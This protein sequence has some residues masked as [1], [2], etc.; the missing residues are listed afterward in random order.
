MA[1]DSRYRRWKHENWPEPDCSAWQIV[2]I[3]GDDF[4]AAGRA[5]GWSPRSRENV[6]MAYGRYLDFLTQAGALRDVAHVGERLDLGQIKEFSTELAR[7]VAP[8][9][10]WSVL[11]ALARAFSA[12]APATDRRQLHRVLSRIKLRTRL[13]RELDNRLID[14]PAL[15]A[16]AIAMMDE[17]E[18]RRLGKKAA[19][20]FRNGLLIMGAAIC[21][22]RRDAWRR[23]TI[24]KHIRFEGGRAWIAFEAGEL[25]ATKRP[26][27]AE[28]PSEY[29]ARLKRFIDHYRPQLACRRHACDS[30]WLGWSGQPLAAGAISSAIEHAIK[31]R[32]KTAFSFHMFR[33]AAATFIENE[34]PDQARMISGVLHHVDGRM[35]E[36]HYIRGQ[37]SAALRAYQALIR[38]IVQTG[39]KSTRNRCKRRSTST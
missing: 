26:L 6:E 10:V 33:H 15:I 7:T 14:P 3:A 37:R 4:D 27:Q 16:A 36:Q 39:S 8:S 11:Q 29:A 35:A 30:L 31:K 34:A 25:K 19:V 20:L 28:L 12:M 23:M 17:A 21:P 13:T 1:S 18:Q 5:T 9:T 22:L 38:R 32:C 24:G 2:N